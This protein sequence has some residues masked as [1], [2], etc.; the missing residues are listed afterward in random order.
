[1]KNLGCLVLMLTVWILFGCTS[2]IT[3][4]TP[5]ESKNEG[6]IPPDFK[7]YTH[8]EFDF[9]IAFPE[10]FKI[11]EKAYGPDIYLE[12]EQNSNK[13]IVQIHLTKYDDKD[14][15][16]H[17]NTRMQSI[18]K[19]YPDVQISNINTEKIK[20]QGVEFYKI[21]YDSISEKYDTK[22]FWNQYYFNGKNNSYGVDITIQLSNKE[23]YIGLPDKI[24]R[25]IKI[26]R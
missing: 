1:M 2:N 13:K 8:K 25:T 7:I 14:A 9:S 11:E 20:I 15:E 23:E 18:N 24:I 4:E 22:Y 16:S 17:F 26:D 10:N 12:S 21:T 5:D 19:G 6:A 3:K